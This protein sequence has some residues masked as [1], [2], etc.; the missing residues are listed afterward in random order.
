[1][2][3]TVHATGAERVESTLQ[4]FS[5]NEAQTAR[6]LQ[7]LRSEFSCQP[8]GNLTV[9]RTFGKAES[10]KHPGIVARMR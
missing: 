8:P 2:C 3:D 9:V 7:V 5:Q 10:L 1:L 6:V 4:D